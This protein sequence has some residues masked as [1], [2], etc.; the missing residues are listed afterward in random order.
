MYIVEFYTSP[1]GKAIVKDTIE[2]SSAEQISKIS[3]V[4]MNLKEFGISREIPNL[5]KLS[6]T[7]LWEYST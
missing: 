7:K 2:Q 4:V 3:R 6:G 5:K 1:N